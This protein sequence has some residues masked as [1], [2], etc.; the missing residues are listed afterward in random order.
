MHAWRIHIDLLRFGGKPR[1]L[2][3]ADALLDVLAV[4]SQ[5]GD[6]RLNKERARVYEWLAVVSRDRG[7]KDSV[8]YYQREQQ[9]QKPIHPKRAHCMQTYIEDVPSK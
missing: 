1:Y 3:E 7:D 4:A 9:V 5:G 2:E 6:S 8:R